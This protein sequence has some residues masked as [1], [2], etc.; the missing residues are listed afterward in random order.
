MYTSGMDKQPAVPSHQS[1]PPTPAS[2]IKHSMYPL[3]GAKLGTFSPIQNPPDLGFGA[4]P[5]SLQQGELRLE[6]PPLGGVDVV[7]EKKEMAAL[8]L[9]LLL[10]P[11]PQ[12]TLQPSR[13]ALNLAGD[14]Y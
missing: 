14:P 7:Q 9:K 6:V 12:A 3:P 11:G 5:S 13:Q 2:A 10:S 4:L 8:Y 1:L